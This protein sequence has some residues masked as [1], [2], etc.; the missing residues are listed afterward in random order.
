MAASRNDM[1]QLAQS[2]PFQNRVQASLL[3]ACVAISNEGWTIP[4]HRERAS[5][6]M[7]VLS[8]TNSQGSFVNLFANSVATDPSVIADA[9]QSGTVALTGANRDAQGAL[10]T[11]AHMDAAVASQYNSYIREPN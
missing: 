6:A 1:Y 8:S 4:F 9:T 7:Q 3:A 10:V 11:D 2:T 5:F